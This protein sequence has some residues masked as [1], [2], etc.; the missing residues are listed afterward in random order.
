MRVDAD[1]AAP[2]LS[3]TGRF[4]A[5]YLTP[6]D[7]TTPRPQLRRL[8]FRTGRSELLNP[9]IDG[10]VA[11]GNYSLPP[12]ISGDGSRVA[13]TSNA[14]RLVPHDTNGTFDAFVRDAST[15]TTIV[16]SSAFDDAVANGPTGMTSLS[17]NGRYVVF[18]SSATDVVPGSTTTNSDV[19]LRDLSTGTTVQVSVRPDGAPSR[20]PGSLSADVSRD[21]GLV[22]FSSYDSDLVTG[23]EDLESDVFVRDMTAGRTRLLSQ[24]VPAGAN[25]DGVEISPNGE[26]VSSRWADGTLHL[27]E[28]ATRV[29]STVASGA[30][31]VKGSFSSDLGRFV[32][33]AGGKPFLRELASGTNTEIAVPPGGVVSTV[34]ISGNG[35]FAAVDWFP[36]GG[37]P[38]RVFR[39]GL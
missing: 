36:D 29:T 9:S 2:A 39:I 19:Y 17:K 37:G 12:L 38:G 25:P 5:Y 21:A 3:Y 6:R 24:D 33:V 13:F 15:N 7:A 23:D 16:A 32:F 30:Y 4:V 20:G 11:R 10:G 27:T 14:A 18:T 31:A 35:R 26:W 1:L 34:T 22:A 8:D 28:V